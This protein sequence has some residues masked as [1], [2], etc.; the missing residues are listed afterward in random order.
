MLSPVGE[1]MEVVLHPRHTVG[2]PRAS[3]QGR[4]DPGYL[5]GALNW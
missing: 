2:S 4:I 1:D 3:T 5:S